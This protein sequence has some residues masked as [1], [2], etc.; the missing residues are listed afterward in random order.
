MITTIIKGRS[1]ITPTPTAMMGASGMAVFSDVT[2]KERARYWSRETTLDS[3][4]SKYLVT[5]FHDIL[6]LAMVYAYSVAKDNVRHVQGK[7]Q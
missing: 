4:L 3:R 2:G 5:Q 7:K 1:K 6:S